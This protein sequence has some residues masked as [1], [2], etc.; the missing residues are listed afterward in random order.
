MA[1]ENRSLAA[2]SKLLHHQFRGRLAQKFAAHFDIGQRTFKFSNAS[3]V[4][5]VNHLQVVRDM[6]GVGDM[7]VA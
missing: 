5:V 1:F 6:I 4:Q 2:D 3:G 7:R